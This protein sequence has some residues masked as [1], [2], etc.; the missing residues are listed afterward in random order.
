MKRIIISLFFISIFYACSTYDNTIFSKTYTSE[1]P[2]K[3]IIEKIYKDSTLISL[4]IPQEFSIKNNYANTIRLSNMKF[5]VSNNNP[6][7]SRSIILGVSN[8]SL[9]YA[10][11]Q[12]KLNPKQEE[13]FKTYVG[14]HVYINLVEKEQLLKDTILSSFNK[15]KRIYNIGKIKE[16]SNLLN[17]IVDD[18]GI[19]KLTFYNSKI[20]SYFQ[21]EIPVKF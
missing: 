2:V 19:I 17:N 21:K 10:P 18:K 11:N 14:S 9:I 5:E 3:V 7:T 1:M 6:I 20:K 4:Y 8:D 16:I 13:K 15:N 12:I